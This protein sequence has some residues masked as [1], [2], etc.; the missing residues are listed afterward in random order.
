M[1]A[2]PPKNGEWGETL[3][4]NLNN[5]PELTKPDSETLK[6]DLVLGRVIFST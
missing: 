5:F 4:W 3:M 1:V 6:V 2:F